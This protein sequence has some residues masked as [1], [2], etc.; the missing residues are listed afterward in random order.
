MLSGMTSRIKNLIENLGVAIY[1]IFSPR[2]KRVVLF[3]AWMGEKFSDNSRYL[4][5][6]IE[7]NKDELGIHTVIWATRN[8]RV[9]DRLSGMGYKAVLCGTKESKYWHLKSGVQIICNASNRCGHDADIDIQ[10]SWGAK[11]IQ[12]W[13]GVG[14]KK[15]GASANSHQD[16]GGS[17]SLWNKIKRNRLFN[18]ITSEGGWNE[19]YFL[20]TSAI[21]QK[22]NIELAACSEKSVFISGYPRNCPCVSIFP[23]EKEIIDKIKRYRGCI[24]YLPTFRSNGI[25]IV[26]PISYEEV[27][28]F[29]VDNNF[30]WIE[31]PHSAS[32]Q[33]MDAKNCKNVL[34]LDASF[35]INVLYPYVSAVVSDYSSCIFDAVYR[36][37]PTVMYTPDLDEFESGANGLL[38]DIREYCNAVLATDERKLI[39]YLKKIAETSFFDTELVE[40][41][42][43][44]AKRDF[45]NNT[46]YSYDEI[47]RD[48]LRLR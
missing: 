11:K 34:C 48:I 10:Y 8:Q 40:Q 14:M 46:D 5:Q 17:N 47:W 29:L 26:Y 38:F 2:D 42:Y 36:H 33:T 28:R 31:K 9:C 32:K 45:W 30:L 6:Y 13:H 24:L 41:F 15:V 12:L 16:F 4:F 23:E 19:A 3:G 1:G 27:K 22:V 35:D 20:S 43:S 44:K 21:N 39:D 25:N 7:K 18:M 37:I